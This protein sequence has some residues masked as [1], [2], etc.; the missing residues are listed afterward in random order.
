[1]SLSASDSAPTRAGVQVSAGG[2]GSGTQAELPSG[3]GTLRF[4]G[5]AEEGTG[6]LV[7]GGENNP[8]ACFHH[9]ADP[10]IAPRPFGGRP[11]KRPAERLPHQRRRQGLGSLEL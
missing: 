7:S 10:I 11:S 9:S 6:L 4:G 2:N 8:V 3:R 1:M 5:E